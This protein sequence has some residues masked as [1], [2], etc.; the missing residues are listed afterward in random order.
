[1]RHACDVLAQVL[2]GSRLAVAHLLCCSY[3]SP[4]PKKLIDMCASMT[5]YL[6]I[7]YALHGPFVEKRGADHRGDE[8]EGWN[9]QDD[10]GRQPGLRL[11]S[12][13]VPDAARRSRCPGKSWHQL[14]DRR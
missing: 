6:H 8:S 9:G 10:H 12:G 14:W 5:Y 2:G 11:G 13:R 1:M 4:S 7:T 3:K